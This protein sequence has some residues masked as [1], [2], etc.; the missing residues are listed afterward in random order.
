M[1]KIA[2]YAVRYTE[3]IQPFIDHYYSD[4]T[5]KEAEK[6]N[7]LSLTIIN[8]YGVLPDYDGITILNNVTR[9]DFSTGHLARSWNQCIINGFKDLQNP[10]VDCLVLIQIDAKFN[11]NWYKNICSIPETCY[12]LTVG[13]G[14]EMQFMRPQLIKS[15]GLYDERYCNI[16]YQ[17]ADYFFRAYMRI[18]NNCIILDYAHQR[19]NDP[20][21]GLF[22]REHFIHHSTGSGNPAAQILSC[23]FHTLSYNI[24]RF[25]WKDVNVNGWVN[26]KSYLDTL[27]NKFLDGKEFRYYPYFEKHINWQ[28]YAV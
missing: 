27:D 9:P 10:A 12:F 7:N 23:E 11:N 3:D 28:I 13:R 15:V 21:N 6:E 5:V 4:P 26:Q 14:D 1:V 24:F 16:G 25:K 8:N 22:N 2:V 19:V 20:F 18:R 17:E